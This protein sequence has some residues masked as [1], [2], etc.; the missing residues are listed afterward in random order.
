LVLGRCLPFCFSFICAFG[1]GFAL[2]VLD[3]VL[4][5]FIFFAFFDFLAFEVLIAGADFLTFDVLLVFVVFSGGSFNVE[6]SIS[7]S[8]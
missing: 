7:V 1:F 8:R 6:G 5:V 4:P 3:M 2:A